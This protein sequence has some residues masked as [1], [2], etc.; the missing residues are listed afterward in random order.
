M[1]TQHISGALP[2]IIFAVCFV[3]GFFLLIPWCLRQQLLLIR[4][5]PKYYLLCS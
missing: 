4:A 1:S 3:L 5:A 2:W